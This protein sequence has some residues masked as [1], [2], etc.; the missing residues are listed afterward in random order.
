MITY[1][2]DDILFEASDDTESGARE[3]DRDRRLRTLRTG[4]Q[5][6]MAVR[7]SEAR[8]TLERTARR[9]RARI[10]ILRRQARREHD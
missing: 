2:D 6:D 7:L 3:F 10:R 8:R 4:A 9:L 1:R 5:G